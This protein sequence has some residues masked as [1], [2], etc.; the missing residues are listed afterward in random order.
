[1]TSCLVLPCPVPAP[2]LALAG[3]AAP[4]FAVLCFVAVVVVLA[5]VAGSVL[6]GLLGS[7]AVVL[8]V[9]VSAAAAAVRGGVVAV[10]RWRRCSAAAAAVRGGVVAAW[11]GRRGLLLLPLRAAAWPGVLAPGW[12]AGFH[13]VQFRLEPSTRV[14]CLL[15]RMFLAAGSGQSAPGT[16]PPSPLLPCTLPKPFLLALP[17]SALWRC[18]TLPSASL[19]DLKGPYSFSTAPLASKRS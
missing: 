15:E 2:G 10:W 11:R 9:V 19:C 8:L 17:T 6:L 1:M 14:S 5:A 12:L 18:I 7:C 16:A 4:C 3:P 13:P